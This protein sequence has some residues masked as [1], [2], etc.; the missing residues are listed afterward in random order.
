MFNFRTFNVAAVAV[1]TGI[2]AQTAVAATD[3]DRLLDLLVKKQLVTEQEAAALRSEIAN[4]QAAPRG[5]PPAAAV[6]MAAPIDV[7]G[8]RISLV[9]TKLQQEAE[10]AA[11]QAKTASLV[12]ASSDGFTIKSSDSA[13]AF[14][15]HGTL[16]ADTR[17]FPNGAPAAGAST[18]TIT[19]V[20]PIFDGVLFKHFAFKIMPDFG[21]GSTTLLD[22]YL[23]VTIRPWLKLR[24]GK[25]KGPVGLERLVADTEVEFYERFLPTNLVPNRDVGAQ[26]F[27]EPWGG[28]V[29]YAGGIFNGVPDGAITDLDT[30]NHR[31]FE[32]RLFFHPFRRTSAASLQ[33]F[34]A[35]VAGTSGSKTGTPSAP[36]VAA[37]RTTAQQNFFRYRSDGTEAGTVVASG[38][39][40][41]ISPQAYY[42]WGA[43]GAWGEYV[44]S[45]QGVKRGAAHTTMDNAAW[46]VAVTYVLTG[47]EAS[48]RSVTPAHPFD[49]K[50]RTWG[51][52]E[53][54]A[55][56]GQLSIDKSAFP[57][58]ADPLSSA[59]AAKS[60][61]LGLNWYINKNAKIVLNYEQTDFQTVEGGVKR[62]QERALMERLQLAF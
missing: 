22:G 5:S 56:Y 32:G 9:E 11:A 52:V 3:V 50:Q 12:S 24:A 34:G 4:D 38:Q 58:F 39:Q 10:A 43:F 47:E 49:A 36:L 45:S 37:Y 27:G 21:S 25:F 20:R 18:L 26:L 14:N 59:S 57:I 41:R 15:L 54:G 33:G 8:Q 7:L 51:A 44:L 29:T 53:V 28:V 35:G 61:T 46:Q 60:W 55:R 13:F 23:D 19:K 17:L 1:L 40:S 2:L 31:E 16:Q 30:D 48:Y 42:Y 62:K 6:V